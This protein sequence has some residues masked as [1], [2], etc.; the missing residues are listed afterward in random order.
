MGGPISSGSSAVLPII[1]PTVLQIS[2]DA[3]AYWTSMTCLYDP[4]WS[5][6]EKATLPVC[7]FHMTNIVETWSNE[8]SRKRVILYEAPG[9][10][11]EMGDAMR[12]GVIKASVDNIVK[13]PKTYSVEAIVPYLPVGR[14]VSSGVRGIT[15]TMAFI[16]EMASNGNSDVRNNIISV[17]EGIMAVVGGVLE[18]GTKLASLIDQ[19][20]GDGTAGMLNKNSLEAMA[21]SGRV[22]CLKMW[23]GYDYKY[24]VITGLTI[25]KK[26]SED[27]VFR[28]S[29]QFQ[30]LPIVSVAKPSDLKAKN[31]GRS[32]AES[33]IRNLYGTMSVPITAIT[34]VKAA[35]AGGPL[36][37]ERK[38][39]G[40]AEEALGGS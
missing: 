21:D 30:E 19:F 25:Q 29:M 23:S 37:E 35:D 1:L 24:V 9:T 14:Y 6:T 5:E 2:A 39:A 38:A 3:V 16:S 17:V 20:T 31:S 4:Y 10:M 27:S 40:A 33:Y 22:L 26:G 12:E 13:N 8:T 32:A 11:E 36:A 7:M 28:A 18:A 15:D 34:G